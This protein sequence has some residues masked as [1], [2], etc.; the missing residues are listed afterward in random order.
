MAVDKNYRKTVKDN[1]DSILP[2]MLD[3]TNPSPGLGW[4]NT[5]RMSFMERQKADVGMALA[6][7]HHIAISNNVPLGSIADLFAKV[8]R[9]LIIEF[10]PKSDSQVER[11]LATR[12]DVFPDYNQIGFEAAFLPFF[13]TLQKISIEDSERTLYLMRVKNNLQAYRAG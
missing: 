2:L 4:A 5:E 3:L 6:L 7:I 9:Y 10:V 11:L 8:C 13:E 12:E 1:E